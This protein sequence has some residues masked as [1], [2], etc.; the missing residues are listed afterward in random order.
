MGL[1]GYL[2]FK[3]RIRVAVSYASDDQQCSWR[4]GKAFKKAGIHYYDYKKDKYRTLGED[5]KTELFEIYNNE[6]DFVVT[7]FSE[8][9]FTSGRDS[10]ATEFEVITDRLETHD[11]G[12]L[13][14][15]VIDDVD[16]KSKHPLLS[17]FQYIPWSEGNPGGSTTTIVNTI[18]A[19]AKLGDLGNTT[20][21]LGFER[22]LKVSVILLLLLGVFK[23]MSKLNTS[24][25]SQKE[26]GAYTQ[27]IS[28]ENNSNEG[29]VKFKNLCSR[30]WEE[31][32]STYDSLN[33]LDEAQAFV[34]ELNRCLTQDSYLNSTTVFFAITS[35]PSPE[36]I[37]S[38]KS[39]FK[40]DD[41]SVKSC[42]ERQARLGIDFSRAQN[43]YDFSG[44]SDTV[45]KKLTQVDGR[46]EEQ[47]QLSSTYVMPASEPY[48]KYEQP[49][50]TTDGVP[51]YVILFKKDKL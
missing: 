7:L 49:Y 16:I 46:I 24:T 40:E 8:R 11:H 14:P 18:K 38:C 15:V 37:K 12:F 44:I 26:P 9:Y 43:T 19:K 50:F 47:G 5:L 1:L 42:M 30:N 33:T 6:C 29:I 45:I 27:P 28:D 39:N 32:R 3:K 2:F 34:S 21:Q 41:S 22:V 13:T 36:A 35:R 25:N 17:P 31:L 20:A 10:I 23:V 48:G 51:V 4:L